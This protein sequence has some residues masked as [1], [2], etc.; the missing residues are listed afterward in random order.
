LERNEI[1]GS[2]LRLGTGRD[3]LR[4][5]ATGGGFGARVGRFGWEGGIRGK[6]KREGREIQE[7]AVK[8]EGLA[9]AGGDEQEEG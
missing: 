5:H 6:K 3:A 8:T 1:K 4:A 9:G 2:L 7:R